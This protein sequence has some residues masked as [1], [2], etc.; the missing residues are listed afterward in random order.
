[1]KPAVH[2]RLAILV[3]FVLS[4]GNSNTSTYGR[5]ILINCSPLILIRFCQLFTHTQIL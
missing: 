5:K 3:I 1:M 4:E 2:F